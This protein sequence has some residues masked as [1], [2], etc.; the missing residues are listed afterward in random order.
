MPI[1]QRRFASVACGL[2]TSFILPA[3]S[4]NAAIAFSELT[5]IPPQDSQ[6]QRFGELV[7]FLPN[8]NIVVVDSYGGPNASGGVWLFSRSGALLASLRGSSPDDHVGSSG[9]TVLAN[10]NFVVCS[11]KWNGYRGAAT[12]MASSSTGEHVVSSANSLTGSAPDDSVCSGATGITALPTGDYVV[13]SRWW[14]SV[15]A[16]TWADGTQPTAA[17]A[18][19]TQS[20]FGASPADMDGVTVTVLSNGNYV[21]AA[22]FWDGPG[23]ATNAGAVVW[24]NGSNA[25]PQT[26][27]QGN[28]LH[29]IAAHELVGSRGAIA[30]DCSNGDYLVHSHMWDG[31]GQD[32]MIQIRSGAISRL[33]GAGPTALAVGPSNSLIGAHEGDL[34]ADAFVVP[35]NG[36][37]YAIA[38]PSWDMSIVENAGAVYV[39]DGPMPSTLSESNSIHGTQPDDWVGAEVFQRDDGRIVLRQG[40]AHSSFRGGLAILNDSTPTSGTFDALSHLFHAPPSATGSQALHSLRYA[41]NGTEYPLGDSGRLSVWF[42]KTPN[43]LESVIARYVEDVDAT[44]SAFD[45]GGYELR[46]TTPYAF[47]HNL[48]LPRGE[49]T[50]SRWLLVNEDSTTTDSLEVACADLRGAGSVSSLATLKLPGQLGAMYKHSDGVII[51]TQA[52]GSVRGGAYFVGNVGSCSGDENSVDTPVVRAASLSTSAPSVKVYKKD[53]AVGLPLENRVVVYLLDDVFKDGFE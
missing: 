34:W 51:A 48:F 40:L 33:S 43:D 41:S 32:P 26:I 45:A 31:G 6:P 5:L 47:Q 42:K 2:F 53:F 3:F 11:P 36:C 50:P 27:G 16:V 17:S 8:G 10:G 19:A 24:R 9:I 35:L 12:W 7:E 14:N 46:V 44:S 4:A 20:L 18:I 23:G 25:S 21:V 38:A 1:L 22:P 28:S 49:M 15:G 37:R 29:G 52:R 30:L 39:S 13:E